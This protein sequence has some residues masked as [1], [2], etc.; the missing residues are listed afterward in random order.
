[1]LSLLFSD[2]NFHSKHCS[3][4]GHPTN[5][6]GLT[7]ARVGLCGSAPRSVNCAAAG[8]KER[9][10]IKSVLISP[11]MPDAAKIIATMM[12]W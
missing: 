9:V 8:E 4:H 5:Y 1:M 3:T 11:A 6:C 2:S 10:R 12:N 7:A